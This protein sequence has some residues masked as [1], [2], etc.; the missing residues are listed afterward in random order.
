[1]DVGRTNQSA[2]GGVIAVDGGG[3]QSRF[4]LL[5]A[6]KTFRVQGGPANVT[7]DLA[8]ATE[9]LTRGLT[10]LAESAGLRLENLRHW[11]A[12]LGLAGVTGPAVAARVAAALPLSRARIEDDRAAAL[13]GALGGRDGA[14]AHCGTGSFLAMRRKGAVRVAGGWGP[15]LG[16]M[17]SAHW[18]GRRV[19]ALTL[20][21]VDGLADHTP[22][23][24]RLL[25]RYDGPS[26]VVAFARDARPDAFGALSPRV[27]KAAGNGDAIARQALSEG[28]D[29]IAAALS[30][31]GWHADMDLC[32][33]GGLGPAYA[34]YLPPGMAAR[35]RPPRGNPL[36]GALALA[37]AFAREAAS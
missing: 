35:V 9:E 28:A 6:G 29:H 32:L 11:P 18:L 22:L 19:L 25:A 23:S 33:T 16:D 1:M 34:D 30:G 15:V 14:I 13:E 7:T 37:Q 5:H 3:T 21:A 26:G 36:D 4:V 2:P 8:G 24:R 20:D 10:R 27:V 12:Y 17:A 31:L